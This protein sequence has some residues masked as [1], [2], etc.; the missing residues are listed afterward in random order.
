MT[1]A[2]PKIGWVSRRD[3]TKRSNDKLVRWGAQ[4][5]LVSGVRRVLASGARGFRAF[6]PPYLS[7]KR[8][9]LL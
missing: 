5:F 7:M 6:A 1:S 3:R 4:G 9:G 8:S 2:A